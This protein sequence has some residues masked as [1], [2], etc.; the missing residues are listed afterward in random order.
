M[1]TGRAPQSNGDSPDDV[2]QPAHGDDSAHGQPASAGASVAQVG[3]EK[4][5][6]T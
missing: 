5:P 6:V 2:A 3:A 1:G 4:V